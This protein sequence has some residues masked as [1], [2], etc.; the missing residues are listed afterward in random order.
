M[1]SKA[2]SKYTYQP[3]MH[4]FLFHGLCLAV[5]FLFASMQ[6]IFVCLLVVLDS[7]MAGM[8]DFRTL[9]FHGR[10]GIS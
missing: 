10:V 9:V 8:V 2:R 3:K 7:D 1:T 5:L 6:G 4:H